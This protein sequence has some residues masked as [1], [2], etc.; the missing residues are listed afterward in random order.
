MKSWWRATEGIRFVIVTLLICIVGPIWMISC[1][2]P[3]SEEAPVEPSWSQA[4]AEEGYYYGDEAAR[5]ANEV[6]NAHGGVKELI[7]EEESGS[8]ELML[9]ADGHV[10]SPYE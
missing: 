10:G 5:V 8:L 7:F 6:C 1:G 9:C 4:E 3:G 2:G